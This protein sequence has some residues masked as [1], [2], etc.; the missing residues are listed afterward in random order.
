T[1]CGATWS[2][3]LLAKSIASFSSV[4]DVLLDARLFGKVRD[5]H[6]ERDTLINFMKVHGLSA[7]PL[8]EST[9][10]TFYYH[11]RPLE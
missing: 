1:N 8:A 5:D 6:R 11:L 10:N 9:P 3:E 2:E 7:T 4:G